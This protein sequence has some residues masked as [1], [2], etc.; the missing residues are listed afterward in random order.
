MISS[1]EVFL[2]KRFES[3]MRHIVSGE[4]IDVDELSAVFRGLLDHRLGSANETSFGAL[5]AALQVRGAKDDEIVALFKVVQDYDRISVPCNTSADNLFGIVGSGKDEFKT[6]N[7]STCSAFVA[8]AMGVL[9]IKNGSRS[10]T[11]AFGTTDLMESL[12]YNLETSRNKHNASLDVAN[13]AFCDAESYFPR[14]TKE[15]VGKILFVN[16]LIYLLS[17]ASGIEFKNIIFGIS[18]EETE[19]ICHLLLKIGIK[20]AL[21]VCG[22]TEEGLRFDEMSTAGIT[23]VSELR[24]G[25]VKTFYLNPIDFGIKAANSK[26]IAQPKT[27]ESA[28]SLFVSVLKGEATPEQIDIVALNAGAIYYLNSSDSDIDFKTAFC[29]ARATINSGAPFD[30]FKKFLQA[31]N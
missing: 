22:K 3:L 12:G 25:K 2:K 13:I 28:K 19:R 26:Q 27:L 11:S 31:V 1:K 5:L 30:N 10:D 23:K 6:F 18:F 9:V 17:I 15:Y 29:K 16:P 21:V 24:N 4:I 7:I 8:A 20:K 14:M